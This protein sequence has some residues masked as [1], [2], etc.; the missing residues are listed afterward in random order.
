M[1]SLPDPLGG[2]QVDWSMVLALGLI[3][4]GLWINTGYQKL[5]RHRRIEA[6]D[7]AL[8]EKLEVMLN[9]IPQVQRIDLSW[10]PQT[11]SA[12]LAFGF[13]VGDFD[14][15]ANIGFDP[16]AVAAHVVDLVQDDL[17]RAAQN[18]PEAEVQ[19]PSAAPEP[20]RR[21]TWWEILGVSRDA[22]TREIRVAHR[23][24]S[25]KKHPDLGGSDAEMAEINAARDEAMVDR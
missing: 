20:A 22:D 1:L 2:L 24:L 5:R 8:R 11:G 14:Y 9:V 23:R 7:Q 17:L 18:T 3:L 15:H 4:A 16:H 13:D 6:I 25:L 12:S 10:S 19:P 21:R